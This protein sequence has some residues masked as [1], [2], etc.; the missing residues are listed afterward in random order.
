MI[1]SSLIQLAAEL[2]I[3]PLLAAAVISGCSGQSENSSATGRTGYAGIEQ[4]LSGRISASITSDNEVTV[5]YEAPDGI[6]L[7][8]VDVR[9]VPAW[10]LQS[11]LDGMQS[12]TKGVDVHWDSLGPGES[13]V[14]D[15]G[16]PPQLN[17]GVTSI[18]IEGTA[19]LQG[20]SIR[21]SVDQ[22][23]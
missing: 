20:N 13:R 3:L 5:R 14:I 19:E 10:Q 17:D 15:L 2:W 23:R 12:P 22:N 18:H 6:G 1:P 4:N 9:A 16:E 11:V 8:N 21:F 7:T